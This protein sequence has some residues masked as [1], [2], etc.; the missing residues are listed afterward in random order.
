MLSRSKVFVDTINGVFN[1]R[2]D[3]PI[4]TTIPITISIFKVPTSLTQANPEAYVPKLLGLGAIHHLRPEHEQMQMYKAMVAKTIHGK[5][6]PLDFKK[7]IDLVKRIAVPSVRAS[8]NM[9]LELTDDALA[10]IMA[11]DGLF[12]LDLLCCYGGIEKEDDV[13]KTYLSELMNDS[14]GRRMAQERILREAMMLE[15]QIPILVLWAI[16]IIELSDFEMVRELLPKILVGFCKHVSPF[17]TVPDYP[18]FKTLTHAHSLD[19]LYHLIMLEASPKVNDSVED[20]G[21]RDII[22]LYNKVKREIQ[23]TASHRTFTEASTEITSYGSQLM[24]S[25]Q[26]LVEQGIVAVLAIAPSP[27]AGPITL[28]QGLLKLPWSKLW[29]NVSSAVTKQPLEE[30]TLV[31]RASELHKAGVKFVPAHIKSIRF[32]S[33]SV[34]FH[35]PSIK[36]SGNSEVIIRNLVAYEAALINYETDKPLILTRYVE[37]MSDLIRSCEDVKVLKDDG[38]IKMDKSINE[39]Q[40]AKVFNGMTNYKSI[41]YSTNTETIDRELESVKSYYNGLWKVSTTRFIKKG[42]WIAGNWCKVLAVVV[43]LL[44]MGIQT[45][46]SVY[47]CHRLSFNTNNDSQS[48][49]GLR[50]LSLKSNV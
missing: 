15:N 28:V 14:S 46:C 4:P 34:S 2:T 5:F 43:L 24:Y 32:D 8:Y 47:E 6:Q 21:F 17:D 7:L 49:Q 40:V 44:L 12:L 11:L 9:Y 20:L 10:C 36:L 27:L 23:K 31:P 48:L 26:D 50:V 22:I 39:I 29:S 33:K 30:E 19:L 13:Y 42:R 38:I 41:Q 45:F 25:N 37:I 16:L 1:E 18:P 3:F 35:L